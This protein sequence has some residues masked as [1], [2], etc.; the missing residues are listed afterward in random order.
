MLSRREWLGKVAGLLGFGVSGLK[1]TSEKL[2]ISDFRIP[3]TLIHHFDEL[4]ISAVKLSMPM[5]MLT[6]YL[7]LDGKEYK[8]LCSGVHWCTFGDWKEQVVFVDDKEVIGGGYVDGD[9]YI[10]GKNIMWW[11]LCIKNIM[12]K[13]IK[14]RYRKGYF[15]KDRLVNEVIFKTTNN[16][17]SLHDIQEYNLLLKDSNHRLWVLHNGE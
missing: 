12:Y 3:V 14:E 10:N 5:G 16:G 1:I 9:C 11:Q 7:V 15:V 13:E 17:I 2:E 4:G 8:T 6:R